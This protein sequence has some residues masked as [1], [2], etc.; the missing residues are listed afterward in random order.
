MLFNIFLFIVIFCFYCCLVPT[1]STVKKDYYDSFIP[2]IKETFSEDFDP[3]PNT[4][5]K[6][7]N[8]TEISC[9][10][11]S[12]PLPC[13]QD[14]SITNPVSIVPFTANQSSNLPASPESLTYQEL[15]EFIKV[16]NLQAMV[17]NVCSKPYNRCKKEELIKA[18]KA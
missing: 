11:L 7:T 13:H 1:Q 5:E 12:F 17:K 18:L 2:S 6:P 10:S 9:L 14:E 4:I 16:H 3:I 8:P 15:K